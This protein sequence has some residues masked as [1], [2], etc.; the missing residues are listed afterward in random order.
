MN[1][2]NRNQF[3]RLTFGNSC[4][5]YFAATR[6]AFLTGSLLP[7]VTALTLVWS[8]RGELDLSLAMLTLISIALIH[9]G[10]NV[11]NDYFDAR[12]G[13]DAI[14]ESRIFPFSGG[15]R[16][17]QNGVL[18]ETQMFRFGSTLLLL[19]VG[20]GVAMAVITGPFL[21]FIGI[22][23]A[24][25]AFFYSAP[26]CLA[27]HGLGDITIGLCFGVLPVTGTVFIQTGKIAPNSLWLG[28]VIACYVCAILWVNSIPDIAADGKVGK[29][30]WPVR[31]GAQVAAYGLGVWFGVGFL[32]L[33]FSPLPTSTW[34]ALLA[35]APA[36][37]ATMSAIGGEMLPAIR[38]TLITQAAVCLLLVGGLV[39]A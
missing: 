14:N 19:G 30:T 33:I 32:I 11:L 31:L 1:E 22:L 38:L 16:F 21:L 17:I 29:R 10:A 9:S 4:A 2:P 7:V 20:L 35:I 37:K 39:V 13:S 36:A 8:E 26:P 25:L 3:H 18:S 6:P 34:L 27:C 23:G 15:S 5:T 28:G 24:L 12:N